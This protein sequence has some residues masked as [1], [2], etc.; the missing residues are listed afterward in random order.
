MVDA[1][2]AVAA[3]DIPATVAGL[4]PAGALGETLLD[5]P[6]GVTDLEQEKIVHFLWE[7]TL[8][9]MVIERADR[10]ASCEEQAAPDT[11]P[12]GTVGE[13][14]SVCAVEGGVELLSEGPATNDQVTAQGVSA[15]VHGFIVTAMSYNAA[16]GKEVPPVTG[17]PPISMD[18]LTMLATS[19]GWFEPR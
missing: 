18:D 3:A 17:V 10:L 15:W 9:S 2:I 7:G 5:P 13:P 8:T 6:Y 16:D 14:T 12:D 4:L 1:R 11:M 19:D